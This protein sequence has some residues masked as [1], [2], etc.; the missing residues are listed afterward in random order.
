MYIVYQKY[1]IVS[2]LYYCIILYIFLPLIVLIVL[3][4]SFGHA[5]FKLIFVKNI[6]SFQFDVKKWKKRECLVMPDLMYAL[7]LILEFEYY[8]NIIFVMFY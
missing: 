8:L 6:G 4:V 7:C 1:Y 3:I 5:G 2:G